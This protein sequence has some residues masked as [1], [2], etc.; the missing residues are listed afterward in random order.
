MNQTARDDDATSSQTP[1]ADLDPN[2]TAAPEDDLDG[3]DPRDVLALLESERAQAAASMIVDGRFLY[4][5]WGVAW[6]LGFLGLYLSDGRTPTVPPVLAGIGFAALLMAAGTVTAIH[7]SRRVRG[8]RGRSSTQGSMYGFSWVLGFAAMTIMGIGLLR[9]GMD[10]HLASLYFSSISGLVVGLLYLGAG[11]MWQDRIMYATGAWMLVVFA[12]AA[13]AGPP[14]HH[15]LM[16]IFGGGGFIIAGIIS[17]AKIRVSAPA[18]AGGGGAR[19]RTP[20]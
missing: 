15:L 2:P 17:G 9:A 12:G 5:T 14:V 19:A 18:Q 6:V 4:L 13:L 3:A 11:A 1:T 16:A 8:I 7:T 20:R 10:E